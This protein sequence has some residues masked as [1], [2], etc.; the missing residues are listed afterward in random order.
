MVI[1]LGKVCD[2][3]P[4]TMQ[5]VHDLHGVFD[6]AEEDHITEAGSATDIGPQ[7]RP[8]PTER[9]WSCGKAPALVMQPVHETSTDRTIA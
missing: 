6:I 7:L 4:P 2:E 9:A 3:I 8:N 5:D 1:V